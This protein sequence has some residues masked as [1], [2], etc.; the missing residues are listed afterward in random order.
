MRAIVL[1]KPA[2]RF[3]HFKRGISLA[4]LVSVAAPTFLRLYGNTVSRVF[5]GLG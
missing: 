2:L 3:P 4:L 1:M 5:N